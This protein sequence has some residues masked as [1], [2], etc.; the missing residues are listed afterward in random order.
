MEN[1][2]IENFE[3]MS[4]NLWVANSHIEEYPKEPTRLQVIWALLKDI[5]KDRLSKLNNK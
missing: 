5:V 3:D 2:P 4:G 1:T